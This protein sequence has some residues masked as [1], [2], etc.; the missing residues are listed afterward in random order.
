M[1]PNAHSEEPQEKC[2]PEKPSRI[3]QLQQYLHIYQKIMKICSS[4][5]LNSE[6]LG[7]YLGIDNTAMSEAVGKWR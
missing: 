4:F 6:Q 1:E 5:C 7:E 2:G 3:F